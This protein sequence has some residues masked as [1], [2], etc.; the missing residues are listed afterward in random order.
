MRQQSFCNDS[1]NKHHSVTL[2]KI[3]ITSSVLP[4]QSSQRPNSGPHHDPSWMQPGRSHWSL[5]GI[6][7]MLVMSYSSAP[8][9]DIWRRGHDQHLPSTYKRK[10]NCKSAQD[11]YRLSSTSQKTQCLAKGC[12]LHYSIPTFTASPVHPC[13]VYS[14]QFEG[15]L[16]SLYQPH[17][18]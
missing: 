1:T 11:S 9:N 13:Y 14:Q 4:Q 3:H 10:Q 7:A 6:D 2:I 15:T 5:T 17:S 16:S 12:S 18:L 8:S